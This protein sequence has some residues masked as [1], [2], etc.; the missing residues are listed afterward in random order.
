[1]MTVNDKKIIGK[2]NVSHE[3]N[4]HG[5]RLQ[6]YILSELFFI[7]ESH[8]SYTFFYTIKFS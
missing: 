3:I 8:K 2:S 6:N 4:S 1:M 5:I 7:T